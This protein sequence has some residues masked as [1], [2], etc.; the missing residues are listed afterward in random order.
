MI[1]RKLR[2][3]CSNKGPVPVNL[4][5]H[6]TYQ[7]GCPRCEAK[8]IGKTDRCLELRLNK[9]SDFRTSA[10][11]KHLYGC[12]HFHHFV[13]S[14]NIF[15]YSNSEPSFIKTWYHINSAISRNTRVID[16]NNNWTQLYFLES[17]Y[18]RRLNP[19]PQCQHQSHQI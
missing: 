2:S 18:I 4:Q 17:L 9:Q 8:Y 10:V 3:F 13:K 12:E 1:R 14:F 16:R 11:G 19:H 15:V 5:S 7:F 6:A